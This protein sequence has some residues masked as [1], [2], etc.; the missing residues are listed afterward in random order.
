MAMDM[1]CV[2]PPGVTTSVLGTPIAD[3]FAATCVTDV[4]LMENFRE[5]YFF[6]ILGDETGGTATPTIT[7]IPSSTAAKTATTTAIYFEYM[8]VSATE[9]QTEWVRAATLTCTAG[10]N[11]LYVISV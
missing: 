1:K 10:D 7:A 9:T 8:R 2:M 11:Q 3:A 4:V 5:A 6:L